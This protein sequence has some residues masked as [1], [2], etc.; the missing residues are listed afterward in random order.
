MTIHILRESGV[1]DDV[2]EALLVKTEGVIDNNR[3]RTTWVEYRFPDS[4]VV[5]H[6]SCHVMLKVGLDAVG[7][8]QHFDVDAWA[9]GLV[10]ELVKQRNETGQ[11]VELRGRFTS[12]ERAALERVF[13]DASIGGRIS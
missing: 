9:R 5:V 1:E 3:E 11:S 2:D 4:D 12:Q 7:A 13:E 10:A 6:R 8:L